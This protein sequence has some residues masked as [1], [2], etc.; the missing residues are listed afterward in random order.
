MVASNESLGVIS[1]LGNQNMK[2]YSFGSRTLLSQLRLA[3]SVHVV[4]AESLASVHPVF[5][6]SFTFGVYEAP[7]PPYNPMSEYGDSSID[8]VK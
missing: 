2:I 5:C 6:F 4:M 7:E 3:S 1:G 8:S